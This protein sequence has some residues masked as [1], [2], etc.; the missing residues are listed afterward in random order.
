MGSPSEALRERFWAPDPCTT[1][2]PAWGLSLDSETLS[3]PNNQ[4]DFP[5]VPGNGK[6]LSKDQL[7]IIR[8]AAG[9]FACGDSG[10]WRT[11]CQAKR[12]DPFYSQFL[13]EDGPHHHVF[14]SIKEELESCISLQS[15]GSTSS[16]GSSSVIYSENGA[17][18]RVPSGST[19]GSKV[20]ECLLPLLEQ[21]ARKAS[22]R[23]VQAA[24]A[25]ILQHS[26]LW[27]Y[28]LDLL[29]ERILEIS[30]SKFEHKLYL[31]YLFHE[32][33]CHIY[34]YD[35][36]M[37]LGH[38][39]NEK[40]NIWRT[41]LPHIR[42]CLTRL[43]HIATELSSPS[44]LIRNGQLAKIRRLISI[45][46]HRNI[47]EDDS[48]LDQFLVDTPVPGPCGDIPAPILPDAEQTPTEILKRKRPF[49]FQLSSDE[50]G[51]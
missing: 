30:S 9:I 4:Q 49:V 51:K 44:P 26:S 41:R 12:H 10:S 36:K 48:F 43:L 50:D 8:D 37:E 5:A 19:I 3:T 29:Q 6:E 20:R 7:A 34:R 2:T 14:T 21:M 22:S 45:W 1:T 46:K 17:Q 42:S 23:S 15:W 33:L 25:W 11:F 28:V 18:H 32:I 24:T 39:V 40:D 27:N 47:F 13:D 38:C 16:V 31:L 35:K